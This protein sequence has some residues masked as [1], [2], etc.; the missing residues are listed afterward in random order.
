M[1]PRV[2]T[3]V[4]VSCAECR[5]VRVSVL[6]M[7]FVVAGGCVPTSPQAGPLGLEIREGSQGGQPGGQVRANTPAADPKEC[8]SPGAV[9]RAAY[10][11]ARGL[12]FD[13]NTLT[14]TQMDER[15]R[16][17]DPA[18]YW[19]SQ[20]Y[21]YDPKTG[22][23]VIGRSRQAQ[24]KIEGGAQGEDAQHESQGGS[25]PG[26]SAAGST[27]SWTLFETTSI[28]GWVKRIRRG[29]L[30]KTSSG[31]LYE[32]VE[33]VVLL[34]FELNPETTVLV[35]SD[36]YKLLVAGV[37]Q[38]LLCRRLTPDAGAGAGASDVIEA[39]IIDVQGDW[40]GLGEY[41]CFSGLQR[42]NIYKLDNGQW[43]QQTD[44]HTRV[45]V[46]V[47]PEVT[48]W[49]EGAIHKMRVEGIETA[50]AVQQLK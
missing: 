38:S 35:C 12:E 19:T 27:S 13:P 44:F 37:S 6:L 14:A 28:D 16:K 39:R 2:V 10:W 9:Q 20:G 1:K 17:S 22:C 46:S 23:L 45:H 50:V 34:E 36:S 32:V 26:G 7:L 5:P 47:M 11:R 31:N 8:P 42:G 40:A 30:L 15:V 49:S 3:P 33:P 24:P 41:G 18:L 43:W 4:R 21:E 29:T 25:S 48:I